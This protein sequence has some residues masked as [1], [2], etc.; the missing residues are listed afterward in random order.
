[1]NVMLWTAHRHSEGGTLHGLPSDFVNRF[2]P[3]LKAFIESK[4]PARSFGNYYSVKLRHNP[5]CK[6]WDLTEC[7]CNNFQYS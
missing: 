2:C 6:T 1:M 7:D 4:K 5:T 3:H